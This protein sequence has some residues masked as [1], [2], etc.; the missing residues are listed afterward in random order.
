[1]ITIKSFAFNPFS[2]NTYVIFNEDKDA[3]ILDPGNFSDE[4][5]NIL[6]KFIEDNDLKVQNILFTM[7]QEGY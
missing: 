6:E 2:E 4:E 1:M 3:F 7:R 5:T